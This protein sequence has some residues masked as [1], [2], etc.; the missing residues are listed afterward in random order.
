[1]L[2]KY[3]VIALIVVPTIALSTLLLMNKSKIGV[4]KHV[5]TANLIV[6]GMFC[7]ACSKTLE[8]ALSSVRGIKDADVNYA[9]SKAVISY[10][11]RKTNINAI[12]ET[13]KRAGF[14]TKDED[15]LK[16]INYKIRFN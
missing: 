3:F 9:E 14:S 13:I 7:D 10:D 8:D 16:V 11:K 1:M 5:L 12:K 2:K 15:E 4:P 6:D